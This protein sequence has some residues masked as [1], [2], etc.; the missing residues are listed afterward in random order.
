MNQL[1]DARP[2][3]VVTIPWTWAPSDPICERWWKSG[4]EWV[5]LDRTVTP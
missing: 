4:D 2:S 3:G 1:T 5:R